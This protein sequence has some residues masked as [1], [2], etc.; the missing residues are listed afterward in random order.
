M[1]RAGVGG[2][3]LQRD[4]D[5]GKVAG[6]IYYRDKDSFSKRSFGTP[7]VLAPPGSNGATRAVGS[8]WCKRHRPSWGA[9][10]AVLLLLALLVLLLGNV[11]TGAVEPWADERLKDRDGLVL[12]L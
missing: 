4:A 12:W 10:A 8:R 7:V 3:D 2:Q 5:A 1:D 6:V 11:A 9:V